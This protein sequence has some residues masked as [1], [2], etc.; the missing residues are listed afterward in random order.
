[1]NSA[2]TGPESCAHCLQPIREGV[3]RLE[4]RGTLDWVVRKDFPA[5]GRVIDGTEVFC[6]I[7]CL[8]TYI[9]V[10]LEK[11]GLIPPKQR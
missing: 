11:R 6:S 9:G 7:R 1:M 4:M 8:G 10:T 3:P 5:A 2:T